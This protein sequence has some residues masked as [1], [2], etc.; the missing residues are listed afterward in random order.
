[1]NSRNIALDDI[2]GILEE[3]K[4]LHTVLLTSLNGIDDKRE[5][6]F[7][8]RLVRG[9]V[10][11]AYSID[12]IIDSVSSVKVKKQ[13]TVIRNILRSGIYQI[14]FMDSVTDF[15]ACD[16]SVKLAGKRGFRNLQGFVNG[17]LRNICRKKEELLKD[18]YIPEIGKS[19]TECQGE[20]EAVNDTVRLAYKYS[21]P[22]WI[23]EEFTKVFEKERAEDA[24][25]YFLK[26]NEI[27]VRVNTSKTTPEAFE[28]KCEALGIK[29]ERNKYIDKCFKISD[30]GSLE[31]LQEFKEGLFVVQDMSSSL[32]GYICEKVSGLNPLSK[33]SVLD[34]C[35]APGGKSLYLADIGMEVT[36]CDISEQK[37]SLIEENVNRCRFG[38]IKTIVNDA[39]VFNP[40]F[41]GKYDIVLCDLPCSGLGIIGKKPD[42]KYNM[43]P[44]KVGELAKL[45]RSILDNAVKYVKKDGYLVFS[46]CTV[47]ITENF[48]NAEYL[49]SVHNFCGV[50]LNEYLPCGIRAKDADD[51]YIQIIPGEYDS[52]GF[53]ISLYKKH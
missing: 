17:V 35:A 10:E 31:E 11:R 45:Q 37:I 34:F 36:A 50:A 44:E 23:V 2:I 25:R 9:C 38:N 20:I 39:T 8:A 12:N 52:D 42:I 26:E 46:T 30:T 3:K 51:N 16:E 28:K 33:I 1:M 49:K 32:V 6:A 21:M 48:E 13:K 29:A 5:K 7:V 43:T 40:G 24:F 19:G 18:I 4:P 41:E 47:T 27:S 15:A 53:F 22:E 14:L